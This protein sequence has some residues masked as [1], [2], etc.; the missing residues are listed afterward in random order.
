MEAISSNLQVFTL[1]LTPGLI[2]RPGDAVIFYWKLPAQQKEQKDIEIID[3]EDEDDE[4]LNQGSPKKKNHEDVAKGELVLKAAHCC[5]ELLK[6]LGSFQIDVP[7]C[8]IKVLRIHLGIGA[9]TIHDVHVGLADRWE[10]FIA[11]EGVN[12]LA[13]V[14]DLA[15]SG[16]FLAFCSIQFH[17]TGELALSHQAL[18]YFS[19]V[20]DI[21]SV[22]IGNYDKRC[23]ILTG[24]E[25]AQRKDKSG[26][27]LFLQ[28]DFSEHRRISRLIT[29]VDFMTATAI[30]KMT[31]E[32]GKR[33]IN[34][35]ALFK[36]QMDLNQSKVFRVDSGVEDLMEMNELRT[37]TTVFIKLGLSTADSNSLLKN[38]QEIISIV[39][40]ACKKYEGSLRQFHVDDKG[41]VILIFFGLPPLAHANDAIYGIKAAVDIK[42]KLS[43][44]SYSFSM[45]LTT[46]SIAIGAVGNGV[47]TEYALVILSF[48]SNV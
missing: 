3:E 47:R 31:I 48:L 10:H 13:T 6:N 25:N 9:G 38:A 29:D 45:G 15:K 42:D 16:T 46:G 7:E 8:D 4:L 44:A 32:L 23:I 33:F 24:L 21:A 36:L 41:A 30:Q 20:I 18:K 26:R 19:S 2:Q 40:H 34:H 1:F 28:E 22:T 27:P 14:L 39:L 12:Q 5:L 37:A 17:S 11:G 35:S 43:K